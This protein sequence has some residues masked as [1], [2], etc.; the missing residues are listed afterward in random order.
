MTI[1]VSDSLVFLAMKKL[2]LFLLWL[3][4]SLP[5]GAQAT[6]RDSVLTQARRLKNIYRVDDAIEMLTDLLEPGALDEG[7]LSELADCHFQNGDYEGA[8]GTYLMLST[9]APDNLLYKIRLMRT[10]YLLK[11]YPQS[12]Q[13]GKMILERDSIPTVVAYVGDAFRQMN[14][15]D[16]ALFYY[17]QAL[18]LKPTHESTVSKVAR[19][20]I[21]RKDYDGA[22][23]VTEPLLA[24]DPDNMMVAP[25]KG[26]ALYGKG[27]FDG[28]IEVYE[29]QQEL[30]D[31]TYNTHYYLGQ[32]Y[33]QAKITYRAEQ[34]L[35]A[36]WQI[37]SSDVNLAYAIAAVKQDYKSESYRPFMTDIKPWLDKAVE[38]LQ[39]D[40]ELMARIHQQYG[41]GYYR[42][43]SYW[44]Q[45]IY[46]YKEAYKYNPK[47]ISA[48]L[49]IAYC[50]ESKKEHKQ[51]IAWYEK[52]MQ[53]ARP[54]SQGYEYAQKS[55][56]Y[57]KGE[58]FSENPE[59]LFEE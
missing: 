18:S 26:L 36:A 38:M 40:P 46:H 7:V 13:M 3:I 55:I 6:H 57:I 17:R 15:V 37:D 52:Y 47:L 24:K 35:M 50:Y 39:P 59:S 12:I 34:E 44:D 43:D 21:N 1:F 41:L 45:A 53:V 49:A 23:A 4:V 56:N 58:M 22:I 9:I 5:L 48:L 30:G 32:S 8:A 11:A 33:W 27:D 16:S 29:R 14:Q 28:A 42:Q 54:G 25:L 20:L 51:A 31:D 2:L 19:L 10:Y